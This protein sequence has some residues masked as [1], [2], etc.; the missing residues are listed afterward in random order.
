MVT[1]RLDGGIV[2]IADTD[3]ALNSSVFADSF[4]ITPRFRW[5]SLSTDHDDSEVSSPGTSDPRP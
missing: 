5:P 4:T 3:R 2:I 1:A